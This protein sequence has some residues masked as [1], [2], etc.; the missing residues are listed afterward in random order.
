[1][2]LSVGAF[3]V[4][5][6][7]A[8]FAFGQQLQSPFPQ[9]A[10]P[11]LETPADNT[12]PEGYLPPQATLPPSMAMNQGIVT[13][14]AP[15]PYHHYYEGEAGSPF[16]TAASPAPSSYVNEPVSLTMLYRHNDVETGSSFPMAANPS[17]EQ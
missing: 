16:P 9:A 15:A 11:A 14:P 5:L 8:T 1:M 13:E 17:G 4:V 3:T 6:F 2:K 10:N 12:N 7:V